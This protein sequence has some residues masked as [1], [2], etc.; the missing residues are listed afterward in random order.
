MN[1]MYIMDYGNRANLSAGA[2]CFVDGTILGTDLDRSRYKGAYHLENGFVIGKG[3]I[4]A[5]TRIN[6]VTGGVLEPGQSL[7]LSF[8]WP[9]GFPDDSMLNVVVG[10][11]TV[12]V[13]LTKIG[14]F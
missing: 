14:D 12:N 2:I 4:T 9:K 1:A 6:L 8:D 5:T 7:D 11:R 10:Q 3:T 13:N